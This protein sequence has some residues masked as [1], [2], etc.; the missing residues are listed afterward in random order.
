[1]DAVRAAAGGAV[2]ALGQALGWGHEERRERR[3][4]RDAAVRRVALGADRVEVRYLVVGPDDGVPVVLTPG[5][6]GS[7]IDTVVP[8]T[9]ESDDAEMLKLARM[10][11]REHGCRVLVHDRI[12]TGG[13]GFY[14]GRR[15]DKR[16]SAD[17]DCSPA[18]PDHAGD[19]EFRGAGEPQLQAF[20]LRELMV[21]TGF[22][23]AFLWGSSA[24][25]RMSLHLAA[26]YPDHV[27]G[28]VLTNITA[29]PH[30]AETLARCYYEQYLPVLACAPGDATQA[31]APSIVDALLTHDLYRG[32]ALRN[33]ANREA[34]AA[35]SPADFADALRAWAAFLRAGDGAPVVGTHSDVLVAV[36]CPAIVVCSQGTELVNDGMHTPAASRALASALAGCEETVVDVRQG[37]WL[38][39]ALAFIQRTRAR[40][41]ARA[42]AGAA[43]HAAGHLTPRTAAAR[44]VEVGTV[45]TRCAC[46]TSE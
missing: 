31:L 1:M 5:G 14:L 32:L 40:E 7:G 18:A 30:A 29:G 36:R 9:A 28:L 33:P 10:L 24:G 21:A 4:A 11:A 17:W 45:N 16:P 42:S 38:P 26:M 12:N 19:A 39:R 22:S 43:Q 23:P 44:V 3:A 25:S 13:S 8:A 34:I 20:F 6:Q 41:G 37:V 15:R 2:H 46:H 27:R 35:T